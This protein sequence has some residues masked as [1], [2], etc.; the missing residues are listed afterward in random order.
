MLQLPERGHDLAVDRQ[1][2]VPVLQKLGGRRSGHE[3]RNA[4][5]A[6][7][8]RVVLLEP[9]DPLVIDAHLARG[10]KR[11][12]DELGLERIERLALPQDIHELLRHLGADA[13]IELARIAAGLHGK[14]RPG[15]K[16]LALAVDQH[17]IE[18]VRGIDQRDTFNIRIAES[19]GP[20]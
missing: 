3:P 2:H 10:K 1:H 17:A 5:G 9:L 19:Q 14:A 16:H 13:A 11:R 4:Q 20:G 7:A 8:D 18:I 12:V 15:R 6:T